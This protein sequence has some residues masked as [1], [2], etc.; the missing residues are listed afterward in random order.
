M[1]KRKIEVQSAIERSTTMAHSQDIDGCRAATRM[2][3]E[4]HRS[5]Q[6]HL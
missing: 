2:D 6:V 4:T 5:H 1:E 3:F